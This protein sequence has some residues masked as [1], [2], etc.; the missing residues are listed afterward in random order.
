MAG[1]L[2]DAA[3]GIPSYRASNSESEN[4]CGQSRLTATRS[5]SSVMAE[6]SF[7]STK[8]RASAR[9]RET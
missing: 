5:S 4:C 2:A 3:D 1:F 6:R 8:S 9:I 7:N